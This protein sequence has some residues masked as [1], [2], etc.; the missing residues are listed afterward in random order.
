MAD[1]LETVRDVIH[2]YIYFTIPLYSGEVTEKD[3]IDSEWVQRLRQIFQ[4]QSAWLIY[5]NAVHSRFQHSLGTMQ[6]AGDMAY[7]LYDKFKEAFPSEEIPEKNYVEE[8]FRLAGLLHDIGHGPFGHLLD[9]LYTYKKYSKTHE[10]ISSAIIKDELNDHIVN[11]RRS[12]HGK[13]KKTINPADIS[14]FIKM[15]KSFKKYKLWEQVFA[16]VMMGTYS[17][18]AM[19]FLLRDQYFCGTTEFGK[20]NY[21]NLLDNTVITENGLTLRKNALPAF[22]TFLQTR[23]NMFRHVYLYEKNELY[24]LAFGK[25]LPGVLKNMRVGNPLKN[26]GRFKRLTDFGLHHTVPGWSNETG[27][28]GSLGRQWRQ[29]LLNRELS[30]VKLTEEEKFYH[31]MGEIGQM[32]D[33]EI[34]R[35][36]LFNKYSSYEDIKLMIIRTDI[37]LQQQ[38]IDFESVEDLKKNDNIKAIS[39]I[40]PATGAFCEKDGNLYI[41]DIPLK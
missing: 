33:A 18:D 12:P 4:L 3:L 37:R 11:I 36:E 34:L 17:A 10:D 9:E 20:I 35:K 21:R 1:N 30:L 2:N 22:R 24:D 28:K 23:F 25:L 40:D 5:P 19:D 32:V 15:P 6:L 38:F 39:I 26:L 41:R 29:L 14:K 16:K 27:P 13:F 7:R 8:I 31:N